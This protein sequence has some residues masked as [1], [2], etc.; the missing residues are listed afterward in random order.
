MNIKEFLGHCTCSSRFENLKKI[1]LTKP[2]IEVQEI[3]KL[4]NNLKRHFKY[5]EL[6]MIFQERFANEQ[7]KL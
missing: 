5:T 7:N 2:L 1:I 6:E 4:H 3:Y